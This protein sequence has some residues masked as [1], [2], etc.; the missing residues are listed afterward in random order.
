MKT[1]NYLRFILPI[2][3]AIVVA[4]GC[5]GIGIAASKSTNADISSQ[6]T[7]VKAKVKVR[8]VAKRL[9]A[10]FVAENLNPFDTTAPA[11]PDAKCNITMPEK[12]EYKGEFIEKETAVYVQQGDEF[13]AT[14]YLKNTGNVTWFGT[15]SG[16]PGITPI[17]LGTAR[18]RDR[19]S[20]LFN[21]GD[22]SWLEPKRIAMVEPRIEP[23]EIATF[24]FYSKAPSIDDVFREYFQPVVEGVKWMESSN[25]TAYVDIIVGG[26]KPEYEK[27][28][29]FMGK[30]MQASQIDPNGEVVIYVD[31]SEQMMRLKIGDIDVRDY[32]I[33]TGASDT[34]TPVG[35][36]KILNKDELR[37]GNKWP[38]YHMPKWQGFTNRGHGLHALPYLA[39]DR[40]VFW[41]EALEHIGRPVSHGCIRLMTEDATEL[42]GLTELEMPIVIHW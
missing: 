41:N 33:S 38:H 26:A 4:F 37:I 32:K 3:L 18:S 12:P 5:I 11:A 7:K 16:C 19:N 39:N 36:F 8:K 22:P 13:K 30:S 15:L 2:S 40:G 29:K 1:K 34:P 28:L 42:Y 21:P 24:T 9:K 23:N 10:A 17:K 25:E 20:V 35:R 31:L 27:A 14:L 6:V